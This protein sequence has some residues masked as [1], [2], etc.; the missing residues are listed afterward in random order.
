MTNTIIIICAGLIGIWAVV[1]LIKVYNY[2]VLL[3]NYIAECEQNIKTILYKKKQILD[4]SQ[5]VI[6]GHCVQERYNNIHT[7]MFASKVS[8]T[9]SD[10][11]LKH[12]NSIHNLES[13]LANIKRDYDAY[14]TKYNNFIEEF[15]NNI[16]AKI[17]NKHKS[18]RNSDVVVNEYSLENTASKE[19]T[20][21]KI[22]NK[23]EAIKIENKAKDMAPENNKPI[24]YTAK[25]KLINFNQKS[26]NT[27]LILE[28]INTNHIINAVIFANN[29][30]VDVYNLEEN[31]VFNFYGKISSYQGK[32][33]F[34][35]INIYS[36]NK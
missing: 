10:S 1:K 25:I 17:L 36:L 8:A 31:L 23:D 30:K 18:Y 9:T 4:A 16:F 22:I 24:T 29:T 28:N 32:E 26:G 19:N 33:Q 27:Y 2:I 3:N 6:E 13:E 11:F 14:I 15:P 21:Q 34:Q 5:N 7:P 20:N 35:I 12:T